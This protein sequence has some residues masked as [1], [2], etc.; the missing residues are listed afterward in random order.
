VRLIA[1]IIVG[2]LLGLT[3]G[4]AMIYGL[5]ELSLWIVGE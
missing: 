2:A 5:V 3:L 4:A 1:E